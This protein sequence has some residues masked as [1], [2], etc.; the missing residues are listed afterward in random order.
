MTNCKPSGADLFDY[1][2]V[3][4]VYNMDKKNVRGKVTSDKTSHSKALPS[5]FIENEFNVP[6]SSLRKIQISKIKS[7]GQ[8]IS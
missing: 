6:I 1:K 7:M 2:G 5:S 4:E 8:Q 3:N